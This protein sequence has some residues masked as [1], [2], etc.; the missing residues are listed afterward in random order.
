MKRCAPATARNRDAILAVLERV[1]PRAGSVLEIAAGTGEHA[2]YFAGKHPHLSWQ[3]TDADPDALP[4]IAAWRDESELDNLR[5][6]IHLDVTSAPWPVSSADAIVNINMIHI[7]PWPVCEALMRGA[8]TIL[9]SGAPLYLYGPMLID[10]RDTAPSNLDFDKWLRDR[11]PRWGI[12]WLHDVT[13][14]AAQHGLVHEDTIDMPANNVS[15]V[16]RRT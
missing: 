15:V 16:F 7:S 9:P 5:A 6:P 13:T 1:L 10:D 12:R 14:I 3:P 4:S 2:A 8:A 11:D